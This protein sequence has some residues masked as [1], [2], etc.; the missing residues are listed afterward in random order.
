M[1]SDEL[2]G[3]LIGVAGGAA[4]WA[5]VIALAFFLWG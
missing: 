1:D 4:V 2:F 3:I 5:I